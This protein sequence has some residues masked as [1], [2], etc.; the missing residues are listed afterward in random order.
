MSRTHSWVHEFIEDPEEDP[1]THSFQCIN[2]GIY[3]KRIDEARP[4]CQGYIVARYCGF[5][6]EY[7]PLDELKFHQIDPDTNKMSC[8]F[9]GHY[10]EGK[11]QH[12]KT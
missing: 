5:C 4:E 1:S 12:E 2:C 11:K 6:D 10:K 9:R 3:A 7:I 8:D